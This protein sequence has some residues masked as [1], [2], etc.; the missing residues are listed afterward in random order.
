MISFYASMPHF[1]R[2]I[3]PI[4]RHIH[5]SLR[6]EYVFDRYARRIP[7]HDLV[8]VASA[9]DLE[10]I[11]FRRA[12][13]VEHGA[14]QSYLGDPASLARHHYPG[15]THPANV[16]G[17]I[18]PNQKVIDS[19]PA[20]AERGVPGAAVGCPALDR[21]HGYPVPPASPIAPT[22]AITFH[23]DARVCPESRSAFTHYSEEMP[24][25]VESLR[26]Q[27]FHVIGHCHPRDLNRRPGWWRRI[28]VEFCPTPDEVFARA[29][30]LI[31][32][33]S[34]IALEFASLGRPIIWLNAPWY[35]RT[36]DHGG[37]F[38]S[39][40]PAGQMVDDPDELMAMDMIDYYVTDPY[41]EH[42]E[43]IVDEVYAF[44]NGTS[45]VRA[46][47]FLARLHQSM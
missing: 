32:D 21:W 14:G 12:V 40:A 3:R 17:Y 38:W 45:S 1:D 39:W 19:W 43:R 18:G 36:I 29:H 26:R 30:M 44:R 35:R 11:G 24:A 46:A 34:S 25:I 6:G 47:A 27:G 37:R 22:I 33:N 10:R 42:R 2:H 7:E 31:V 5:P 9:G 28:G 8:V 4:W 13:Y 41:R 16:V 23:W 15:G 20:V